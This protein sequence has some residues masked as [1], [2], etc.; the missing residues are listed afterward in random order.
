MRDGPACQ[1]QP[2][3]LKHM[4][5]ENSFSR[6]LCVCLHVRTCFTLWG[7]LL[8]VSILVC[9]YWGDFS[10]AAL[11]HIFNYNWMNTR[12][13]L[14]K[15]HCMLYKIWNLLEKDPWISGFDRS[16][17]ARLCL[18]PSRLQTHFAKVAQFQF[19]LPENKSLFQSFVAFHPSH[20]TL[21]TCSLGFHGLI[22]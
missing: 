19:V 10:V 4:P 8:W 18:A 3:L 1:T 13:L 21:N 9:F 11:T 16:H 14:F 7:D 20:V 5:S 15:Y 2:V 12:A 6:M 22:E 17:S